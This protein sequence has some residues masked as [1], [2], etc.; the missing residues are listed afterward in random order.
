MI[1]YYEILE[2]S[3][4]ASDTV[5][6]KA[7]ATLIQKYQADQFH[8]RYKQHAVERTHL[9]NEAYRV[10][11]DPRERRRYDLRLAQHTRIPSSTMAS[12]IH[13][14]VKVFG[15]AIILF[16]GFQVLQ[17]IFR[18]NT[19][20]MLYLKFLIPFGVMMFIYWYFRKKQAQSRGMK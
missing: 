5:L 9:I 4:N 12:G 17:A 7:Y 19:P 16:L 13:P 1:D 8:S 3:P 6:K 20:S 14:I 18:H 2:V 10:L 11:S 15:Y